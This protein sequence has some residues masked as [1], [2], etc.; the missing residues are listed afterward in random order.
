MPLI[1]WNDRY[2]TGVAKIDEQ[3]QK[4]VGFIN[5]LNDAFSQA[6]GNDVVGKILTGLG[7]YTVSHFGTEQEL[8]RK[9]AYPEFSD[10]MA[11]HDDLVAKVVDLTKRF[12]AGKMFLSV[13]IMMFL[14]TWLNDH[15][16]NTDKKLGAF[17][18][19]KGIK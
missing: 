6:K 9:H 11:K 1:T 7:E 14:K 18:N 4:L 2:V 15:I 17:L 19:S 3:H 12:Q 8:M 16:L 5:D 10:H 13:E